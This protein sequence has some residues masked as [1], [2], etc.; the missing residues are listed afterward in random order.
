MKTFLALLLVPSLSWGKIIPLSCNQFFL[1]KD[2]LKF[3]NL[4]FIFA[5]R[6]DEIV[7]KID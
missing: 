3:K 2:H 1:F 7:I 5:P 4:E 6:N